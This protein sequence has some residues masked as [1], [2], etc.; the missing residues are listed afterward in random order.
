MVSIIDWE[1]AH[2]SDPILDLAY[3]HYWHADKDILSQLLENYAPQR[4]KD[5]KYLVENAMVYVAARMMVMAE[6]TQNVNSNLICE[7]SLP[8]LV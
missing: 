2:G 3:F 4:Q 6:R 5:L 8:Y 7:R 1:N